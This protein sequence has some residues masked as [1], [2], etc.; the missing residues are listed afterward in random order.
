MSVVAAMR[1]GT[2]VAL[3]HIIG[4]CSHTLSCVSICPAY[5]LFAEVLQIYTVRSLLVPCPTLSPVATAFRLMV[6]VFLAHAALA[7]LSFSAG[8]SHGQYLNSQSP[9]AVPRPDAEAT[10]SIAIIGAG[11]GGLA[12]L[13][14]LLDLPEDVRRNWEIVLYEQHSDVGGLWLEDPIPPHPPTLPHTPLYPRLRTNTPHPTMTYPGFTFPPNTPLFPTHEYVWQYHV[15]FAKNYNLT[16]YIHLNHTVLAAGWSGTRTHGKWVVDIAL[17]ELQD[18]QKLRKTFDHLVVANGHNHYPR[19]P[20][21]PGENDWLAGTGK[22]APERELLH[23]IF[24]REPERYINRTVVIVGGG[25]SGRDAA[26][27][28]GPLTKVCA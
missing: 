28:V 22:G 13:K 24:Y 17:S 7:L 27:Q 15:D 18:G 20:H 23:S 16:S 4:S 14:T 8:S 10:K 2:G 26:L 1:H 21:W 3:R 19:V 5:A 25:A 12:A 11:S 9:L 6:G